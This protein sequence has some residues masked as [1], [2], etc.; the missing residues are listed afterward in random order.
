[1]LHSISTR[2]ALLAVLLSIGGLAATG[3][4]ASAQQEGGDGSATL[5]GRVVGEDGRPIR[6][7]S[8]YVA[9]LERGTLTGSDGR[10]RLADLPAAGLTVRYRLLGRETVVRTVRLEPGSPTTVD[11]TLRISPLRSEEITVTGT[12]TAQDPLK[13]AQ[14]VDVVSGDQISSKGAASLGNL[15][16][17]TVP[18]VHSIST[19]SQAGKP[20]LRGL[21]GTRIRVLQDGVGRDF[22]QYG[23]RHFPQTSMTEAE[24][25]E[26]VKGAA[27]IQYGSDALGGAVN[28]ITRDLPRAEDGEPVLGGR[29]RGQFFSNNDERAGSVDLHGAVG[30]LGFRAGLQLRGSEEVTTPDE[31]TFFEEQREGVPDTGRFGTPKYTDELPFTNFDQVSGYAQVGVDASFGRAEVYAS[32]WDNEHNFLLPIGGEPGNPDDPP[33]EGIGQHLEQTDV[34][35]KGTV[36]AGGFVLKPTLGFYRALRQSAPPT[37]E[38][39]DDP[40]FAIDLEKDSYTGRLDVSHPDWGRLSGSWGAELNVQDTES[41]GPV[42]LEPASEIL[43][44]GVYAFEELDLEPLTLSA[45]ARYDH[46]EQDAEPNELTEDPALLE[47]EYDEVTGGIGAN[48]G[49]ADGLAV[50]SN[51]S[52]GFRAPA[53]FELYA[54]GVHGGVAAFQRGDPTLEPERSTSVDLSL[55]ARTDRLRGKVT[56]YWNR[57]GDYIFLTSTGEEAPSGLPIFEARQTDARIYGLD[58]TFDLSV[59]RWLQLGG[60]LSLIESEGDG[61]ADPDDPGAEAGPLPLIPADRVD[62]SVRVLPPAP[63]R[64]NQT[65]L[66]LRVEHAFA[67]D[68][69]GRLEP[70]SQF[71]GPGTFGTAST[72]AFTLLDLEASTRVE[73]GQKPL[74][75]TLE[76][77][78]LL[79]EA[80]REFL[81]TYK[82]Y[83]LSPGRNVKATVSVPFGDHAGHP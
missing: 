18:G 23:V 2:T 52:F 3:G 42:E 81:D 56:G 45:G 41:R 53:I 63:D 24:R 8:V 26:V 17:E 15:L 14:D 77:E 21:S 12:P 62:G 9:S 5:T 61:L 50:A 64:L 29:V 16:S 73:L 72:E 54:S 48:L 11:V 40:D 66:E 28:V 10:Y 75:V 33:P 74:T 27:S 60:G 43:N 25:V 67:K 76:V 71:D 30:D 68:A 80:Y 82:G 4:A 51:L 78:N 65:Y 6:G 46:R 7:V 22:F 47:N 83:A 69:A 1:M 79:D 58:A 39:E 57:I 13:V 20:V 55:R 31:T 49:L 19:G 37:R 38:I 36:T 35:A 59:L 34:T 70:F 44:V 32:H